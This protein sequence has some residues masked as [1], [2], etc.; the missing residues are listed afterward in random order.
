M[1]VTRPAGAVPET[2]CNISFVFPLFFLPFKGMERETVVENG[3]G[4]TVR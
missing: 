2:W 3:M 4:I 1:A